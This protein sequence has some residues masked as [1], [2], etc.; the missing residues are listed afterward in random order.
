MTKEF[1]ADEARKTAQAMK[2]WVARNAQWI[3]FLPEDAAMIERA[4]ALLEYAA[5]EQSPRSADGQFTSRLI[6]GTG[7]VTRG[8]G[9][10]GW[11]SATSEWPPALPKPPV[12]PLVPG[13]PPWVCPV[14]S[15]ECMIR[16]TCTNKCGRKN[17]GP[18]PADRERAVLDSIRALVGSIPNVTDIEIKVIDGYAAVHVSH[19]C[20]QSTRQVKL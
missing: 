14:D 20:R 2:E 13:E 5:R 8:G 17:S 4:A 6:G 12:P 10:G 15:G 16:R 1:H 19:V 18:T 11:V 3:A 7:G 9:G